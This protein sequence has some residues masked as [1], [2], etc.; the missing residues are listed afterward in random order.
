MLN[1]EQYIEDFWKYVND[2]N[3]ELY[4][5]FSL[6]HELGIFLRNNLDGYK[7]QFERNV[8]YFK[9]YGDVTVKKE[10]DITIFN[11]NNTELYAIE[12]KFP[13]NGQVPERMYS[14]AK[15]ILFMEQ[16]KEH[17]FTQTYTIAL[18]DDGSYYTGDKADGIYQYFR[19][20][21]TINGQIFKPTGKT[22]G[23]EHITISGNYKIEW[24]SQNAKR[25]YFIVTI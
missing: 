18:V 12:L 23:I 22:K 20:D 10:I 13:R 3:I 14:F 7:V 19:G 21:A 16:L 17:G 11:N 8:T 5:E 15:D 4:N 24:R 25:K 6:Q 1:I 9:I 2:E